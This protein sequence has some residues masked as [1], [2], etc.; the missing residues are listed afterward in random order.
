QKGGGHR[1]PWRGGWGAPAGSRGSFPFPAPPL[2]KHRGG[3]KGDEAG[4]KGREQRREKGAKNAENDNGNKTHDGSNKGN[5][6]GSNQSRL[7]ATI[8]G[9]ALPSVVG[10]FVGRIIHRAVLNV[11]N[12]P[13]RRSG[14]RLLIPGEAGRGKGSGRSRGGSSENKDPCGKRGGE[15]KIRPWP[16]AEGAAVMMTRET[17]QEE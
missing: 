15:G 16:A 3:S 10:E 17:R 7:R 1:P 9:K 4:D 6:T 8:A 13:W 12:R 5:S 11:A 2:P 14:L